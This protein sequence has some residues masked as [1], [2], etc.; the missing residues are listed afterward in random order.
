MNFEPVPQSIVHA[1][2]P[3]LAGGA[4]G[5]QHIRIQPDAGEHLGVFRLGPAAKRLELRQLIL[6]Q[7]RV[8]RVGQRGSG[9]GCVLGVS[10]SDQFRFHSGQTPVD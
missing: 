8:V 7:R 3:A 6:R 5:V 10:R 9:D 2:L 1:C 4:E